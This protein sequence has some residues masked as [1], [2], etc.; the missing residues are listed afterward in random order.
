M[1]V[2]R[3]R[4]RIEDGL[5]DEEEDPYTLINIEDILSP[6]EVPTDIVRRPALRRILRSTQIDALSKTSMEFIEGEKNFNKI[7]CRLSAILHQDDPRYLD[8]SF[9]RTPTQIKKYKEDTEAAK[10]AAV[11]LTSAKN[12]TVIDDLDPK[13]LAEK[14]KEA[15]RIIPQEEEAMTEQEEGVDVEARSIVKR[16]KELLLENINYSNEYMSC[17]Q[18]ARN[19]LCKASMQKETLW[20]ELLANAKE[21][22]RRTKSFGDY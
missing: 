17:L 5:S 13:E 14:V 2:K 15:I 7:L 1:I 21:E 9:D 3:K 19:K 12:E 20:K 8:L 6:I 11:A 22:D 10:A 4:R 16:V 18:E